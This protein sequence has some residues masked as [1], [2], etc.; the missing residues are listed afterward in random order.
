MKHLTK[1]IGISMLVFCL[2][3]SFSCKD[4]GQPIA[5][6]EKSGSI[7]TRHSADRTTATTYVSGTVTLT[8]GS[9]DIVDV[10]VGST[11]TLANGANMNQL[12]THTGTTTIKVLSGAFVW[13]Y[14]KL[15]LQGAVIFDNKGNVYGG[16]VLVH[17]GTFI[18]YGSHYPVNVT[19][20]SGGE[21]KSVFAGFCQASG[22][23]KLY[24]EAKMSFTGCAKVEVNHLHAEAFLPYTGFHFA[25]GRGQL[26]A[27]TAYIYDTALAQD[28]TIIFCCPSVTFAGTGSTGYATVSCTASC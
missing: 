28:S 20:E 2:L 11:V 16:D 15:D 6:Q 24:R 14:Q 1:V 26:K 25:Y 4:A 17:A 22:T 18:N 3:T 10:A 19:L 7:I 12:I 23:F 21:Y 27:N 5:E 13:I 8:A 9:Y